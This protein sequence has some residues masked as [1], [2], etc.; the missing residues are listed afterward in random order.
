[1]L[2]KY[3]PVVVFEHGLGGAD[4]YGVCPEQMFDLLTDE[5]G[6]ACALL[7]GWTPSV[8]PLKKD[9]FVAH[10]NRGKH[11]MFVAWDPA[12]FGRQQAT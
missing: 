12:G 11:F 9:E 3:K 5:C 10:F 4:L 8:T 2:Q 7:H 6:L 1:L